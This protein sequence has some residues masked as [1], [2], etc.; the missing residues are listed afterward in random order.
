[1]PLSDIA[2]ED[3]AKNALDK[4]DIG[5]I[6]TISDKIVGVDKKFKAEKFTKIPYGKIDNIDIYLVDGDY[7]M[8]HVYPDFTQGGNGQIYGV[9][10]KEEDK[11]KFIPENE[12]WVDINLDSREYPFI[13][14]HEYIEMKLMESGLRY[15]DD[16]KTDAHPIASSV[17]MTFRKNME[18]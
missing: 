1:M 15:D 11:P 13:I 16:E 18:I 9:K 3:T 12:I 2:S 7:I 14:L 17:E 6:K 4:I 8:E 5:E 10:A